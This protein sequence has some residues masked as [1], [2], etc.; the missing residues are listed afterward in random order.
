MKSFLGTLR[1]A[2]LGG[3]LVGQAGA[4]GSETVPGSGKKKE[5]GRQGGREARKKGE[6]AKTKVASGYKVGAA[7]ALCVAPGAMIRHS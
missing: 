5:E 1:K 3:S 2:G 6:Q 4:L 7:W